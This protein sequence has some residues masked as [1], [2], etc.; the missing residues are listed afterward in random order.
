MSYSFNSTSSDIEG[1]VAYFEWFVNDEFI[2]SNRN[3]TWLANASGIYEITLMVMDDGGLWSNTTQNIEVVFSAFEQKNFVVF[4]SS[5][6]IEPGDSFTMDFSKTTGDVEYYNI[7]V[8]NP[9]GSKDSYTVIMPGADGYTYSLMFP[10]KGVY[11]LDITVIWADG[12]VQDNMTDFYGP[13]VHVGDDETDTLVEEKPLEE[14]DDSGLP[15]ISILV[16][17]LITSLIA[18]SRRQR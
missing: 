6:N 8:N 12:I 13:T 16:T 2:S 10:V 17:L 15:S 4:F 14:V 9:D 11:G 7:V 1:T 3:T 18:I 5:K